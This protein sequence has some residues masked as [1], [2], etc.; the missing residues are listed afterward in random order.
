MDEDIRGAMIAAICAGDGEFA[1]DE[2]ADRILSMSE[3]A[4]WRHKAACWDSA[5]MDALDD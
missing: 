4:E 1:A 3:I 2:I 5:C